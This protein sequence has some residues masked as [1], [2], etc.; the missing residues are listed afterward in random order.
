MTTRSGWCLPGHTEAACSACDWRRLAGLVTC[1]CPGH[2]IT[3]EEPE[4]DG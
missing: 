1:D 2:H 3:T 4:T